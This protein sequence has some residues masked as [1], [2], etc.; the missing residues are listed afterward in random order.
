MGQMCKIRVLLMKKLEFGLLQYNVMQAM[1]F[2]T[3]PKLLIQ[4]IIQK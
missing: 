3:E 1:E 2:L 4:I